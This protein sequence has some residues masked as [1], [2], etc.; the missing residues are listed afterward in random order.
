MCILVVYA[1]TICYFLLSKLKL[2]LIPFFS[3]TR[4]VSCFE[5]NTTFFCKLTNDV[6]TVKY[7]VCKPI[8]TKINRGAR[9]GQ[10]AQKVCII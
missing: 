3:K 10:D 1:F 2:L 6:S 8:D 5:D 4:S 9:K 7:F